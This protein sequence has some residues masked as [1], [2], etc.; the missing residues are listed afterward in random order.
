M[1]GLLF[2]PAN[3]NENAI[4]ADTSM[5]PGAYRNPAIYRFDENVI[6]VFHSQC[7]CFVRVDLAIQ[8]GPHFLRLP[9]VMRPGVK[10]RRGRPPG[11]ELGIEGRV[12]SDMFID[13]PAWIDEGLLAEES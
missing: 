9:E 8:L 10:V 3:R 2:V 4:G 13:D 12:A 1:I 7:R 11:N 5:Q 6:A